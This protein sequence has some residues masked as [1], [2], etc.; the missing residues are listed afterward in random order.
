MSIGRSGTPLPRQ[1]VQKARG[2]GR[3]QRVSQERG[4][5]THKKHS[6]KRARQG[7]S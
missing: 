3:G 4:K 2:E 5:H 6:G 1:P 7:G